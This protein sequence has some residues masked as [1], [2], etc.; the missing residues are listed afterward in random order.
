[1]SISLASNGTCPKVRGKVLLVEDE[2]SLASL[3]TVLAPHVD[4]VCTSTVA[5]ALQAFRRDPVIDVLVSDYHLPDG[6]GL[7]ILRK[8]SAKSPFLMGIILTSHTDLIQV[9]E[10]RRDR[11]VFKIILR[12]FDPGRVIGW[13]NSAVSL[14]QMRRSGTIRKPGV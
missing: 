14:S 7:E 4:T 8:A 9:V 5:Q 6:T 13:V 12:P 10:A 3:V 2:G 11:K 1:M